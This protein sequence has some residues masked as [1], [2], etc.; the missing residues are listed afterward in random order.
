MMKKK[1]LLLTIILLLV[2]AFCLAGCQAGA[3]GKDG[4]VGDKGPT[5]LQGTPGANGTNGTNGADGKDGEDGTN[6]KGYTF[7]VTSTGGIEYLLEGETEWK[8]LISMDDLIGHSKRY[9]I[10]FDANGGDAV[11]SLTKQV[12]KSTPTLPVASRAGY[13]FIGW[14]NPDKNISEVYAAGEFA[15]LKDT[16]L[17]AVWGSKVKAESN[18]KIDLT[19]LTAGGT[20][21]VT[22][23]KAAVDGKTI[24]IGTPDTVAS[25]M[26]W[27]R[28]LLKTLEAD[29]N[30]YEISGI[31]A[32]G[33]SLGSPEF[34]YIIGAH[35]DATDKT[36]YK[37]AVA[38]ANIGN[39]GE[40]VEL[41]GFD[42]TSEEKTCDVTVTLYT[43]LKTL[44]VSG[45]SFTF[46]A[47]EAVGGKELMG[48]TKDDVTIITTPTTVPDGGAVY[49]MVYQYDYTY[50]LNGGTLATGRTATESIDTVTEAVE[51]T[52]PG[53]TCEGKL[54]KGWFFDADFTK[55]VTNMPLKSTKIYAKFVA[56]TTINYD[57]DG[58]AVTRDQ[59]VDLFL[60]DAMA[61]YK[62]TTK[63][64]K[65]VFVEGTDDDKKDIGFAN[66][67]SAIYTF[68]DDPVYGAKWG[69]IRDYILAK[70]KDIATYSY[71]TSK[72]ETAWRYA[73]GAFLFK[74]HR[75][76]WIASADF[77]TEAM[78]GDMT[79]ELYKAY[80]TRATDVEEYLDG[81]KL[82]NAEKAGFTFDGWYD[83]DNKKVTEVPTFSVATTVTLKAKWV[84]VAAPAA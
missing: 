68:F 45:N 67:F 55:A 16:T 57:L 7:R 2:C 84:A 27:D 62:K 69:W 26:Y 19:K 48:W 54:F 74:D 65:M 11:A 59:M 58:G 35:S 70:S 36:S 81:G 21:K 83:A 24:N 4:E 78:Y 13:T 5:G 23:Y 38:M 75:T 52:L 77:T 63:P 56:S 43:G 3:D 76:T 30:I 18:E 41:K 12:Y 71:L 42:P 33:K 17:K 31:V 51:Y 22:G 46:P 15:V 72:N 66:V 32:S 53:I 64:T 6:A 10:S 28:I 80:F 25:G 14:Q 79:N 50:E 20:F 60:A 40:I 8:A 49:K 29:K 9:T 82:I 39:V 73:V 61:F 44:V 47:R 34:D 37:A 1:N